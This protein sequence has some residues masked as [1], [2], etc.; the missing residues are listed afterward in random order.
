MTIYDYHVTMIQVGVAELKARLSEFLRE[1]RGG[2]EVVVLDRD[3][4]VARL[5]PYEAGGPLVVR[6]PRAT[7]RSLRD[8]PLPPPVAL[9]VDPVELLL[10][11]RRE[12]A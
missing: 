2:R 11:D 12:D 9:S 10:D 3:R 8:V 5:V 7:Y 1:V 4:P 6:E